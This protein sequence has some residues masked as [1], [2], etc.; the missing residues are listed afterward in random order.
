MKKEDVDKLVQTLED[1]LT[2]FEDV[3]EAKKSDD[4]ITFAEGGMLVVKHGGK[5]IRLISSLNEL[6]DEVVDLDGEETKTVAEIVAEHFG[7]SEDV[8]TAIE[9]IATGAG[10][11]NQGIQ[12]LV[13]SKKG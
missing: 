8:K 5:A 9:N 1:G 13:A 11:L 6:W 10:Y 12:E 7:T 4:K 3:M 2:V